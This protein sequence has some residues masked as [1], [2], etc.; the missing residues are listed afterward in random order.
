MLRAITQ[1]VTERKPRFTPRQDTARRIA[2]CLQDVVAV[3]QGGVCHPEPT[4]TV[5]GSD[6]LYRVTHVLDVI[7][8][9]EVVV[10]FST[11]LLASLLDVPWW[12]G[13]QD[14]VLGM[15][16]LRYIVRSPSC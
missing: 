5:V 4:V 15:D 10:L 9:H 1:V 11:T 7:E 14:I 2:P 16:T 13:K 8:G 6:A 3:A 12:V